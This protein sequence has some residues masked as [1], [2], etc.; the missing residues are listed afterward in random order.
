MKRKQI[1]KGYKT[2]AIETNVSS[3][4]VM[5]AVDIDVLVTD[6]ANGFKKVAD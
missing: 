4:R 3:V 2:K 1:L 6:N 5:G